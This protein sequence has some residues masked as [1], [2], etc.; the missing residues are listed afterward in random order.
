M[1]INVNASV[2]SAIVSGGLGLQRASDGITEAAVNIAQR[3]A[4]ARSPQELLSDVATQQ[5][6]GVRSLL[7]SGGDSLTTDLVG[8]KVNAINA[9][10]SAKVLD[11][12]NDTVGRIIDELA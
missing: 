5:L 7:P 12:A 1:T 4:Q 2:N 9:Q 11:V 3:N 10:A 6:G 8:L